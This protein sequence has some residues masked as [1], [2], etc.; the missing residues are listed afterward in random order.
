MIAYALLTAITITYVMFYLITTHTLKENYKYYKPTYL[1]LKNKEH[2]LDDSG[3]SDFITFKPAA[4]IKR[5]NEMKA[6][7]H[8]IWSEL[9]DDKDEIIY[10]KS[11]GDIKLL[12]KHYIHTDFMLVFDLYTLYWYKKI[13]KQI[14]LNSMSVCESRDYKLKQLLK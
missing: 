4:K 13:K 7:G 8:I 11:D 14:L 1:V 2:L 9:W 6:S 5:F 10:F 12:S 3:P